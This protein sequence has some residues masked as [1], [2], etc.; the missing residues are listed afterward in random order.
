M[1]QEFYILAVSDGEHQFVR[2]A[3]EL[4]DIGFD[5]PAFA[6]NSGGKGRPLE[7]WNIFA[8]VSGWRLCKT[9]ALKSEAIYTVRQR[10]AESGLN[11]Y[12]EQ[13]KMKLEKYGRSPA[14]EG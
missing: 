11:A 12:M 10:V 4:V 9:Y 1:A 2:V 7:F 14:M 5:I 3:A 8:L 6:Y 13:Q